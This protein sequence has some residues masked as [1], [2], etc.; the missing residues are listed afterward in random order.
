[1]GPP[2]P[3]QKRPRTLA[4]ESRDTWLVLRVRYSPLFKFSALEEDV[5]RQH[6]GHFYSYSFSDLLE[7]SEQW[8]VFKSWVNECTES[9]VPEGCREEAQNQVVG[10]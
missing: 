8:E 1:M 3:H 5:V 7:E 9:T 6:S 4:F 2:L 10:D